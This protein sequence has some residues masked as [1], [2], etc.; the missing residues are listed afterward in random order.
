M[1]LGS[2]FILFS[3]KI[4]IIHFDS[5]GSLWYR[6]ED[7]TVLLSNTST[8]HCL[9][10][11]YLFTVFTFRHII[12]WHQNLFTPF[13]TFCSQS[14]FSWLSPSPLKDIWLFFILWSTETGR[15]IWI[16]RKCHNRIFVSLP[17]TY[18]ISLKN[19]DCN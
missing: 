18:P 1:F 8:L 16:D 9:Y 2:I 3:F 5:C 11:Y 14:A 13:T 6:V 17:E 10:L 12:T 7:P 4:P 15:A 19:P